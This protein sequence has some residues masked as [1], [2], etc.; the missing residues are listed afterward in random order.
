MSVRKYRCCECGHE[1]ELFV[2]TFSLFDP[3]KPCIK[4]RVGKYA[5]VRPAAGG[6]RTTEFVEPIK[7]GL[8]ES[9][10]GE[11]VSIS[12]KRQLR[13]LCKRHGAVS[14]YLEGDP[15]EDA[16][17]PEIK[18]S[19]EQIDKAIHSG[20]AGHWLGELSKFGIK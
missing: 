4:C 17:P 8:C 18:L 11:P 16:R 6:Q 5:V 12:S 20:E 13:E 2:G 7:E 1:N 19:N 14:T 10:A 3:R 15:N 9:F